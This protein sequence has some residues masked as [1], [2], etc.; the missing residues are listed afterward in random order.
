MEE[1]IKWLKEVRMGIKASVATAEAITEQAPTLYTGLW[2]T[3]FNPE[4]Q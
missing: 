4:A 3:S 1:K 2:T